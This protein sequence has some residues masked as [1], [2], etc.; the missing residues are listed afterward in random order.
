MKRLFLHTI[1]F[2]LLVAVFA[3]CSTEK[4]TRV[5]RA[6]HNVTSKYNIYFNANESVKSGLEMIDSR[7]EDD[8]THVLPIFKESDPAAG[9]MVKS[10]MDYA[11]IKCSKLIEIHS[12]TKKPK[13]KIPSR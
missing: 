12:I 3:G 7:I 11:V 13:R 2:L 6:Y 8:Y 4:N 9:K 5:S 10:D 1:L